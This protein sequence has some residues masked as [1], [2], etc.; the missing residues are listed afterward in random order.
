M[1]CHDADHRTLRKF[2][3]LPLM[4]LQLV[5]FSSALF[6]IPT[7]T[8]GIDI[9]RSN[10]CDI[11]E[12]SIVPTRLLKCSQKQTKEDGRTAVAFS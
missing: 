1:A 7:L 10:N 12:P 11:T 3:F 9:S 2:S 5:V 8:R 6:Q 4:R